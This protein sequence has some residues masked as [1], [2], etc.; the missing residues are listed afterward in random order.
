M[1]YTSIDIVNAKK[2]H[3]FIERNKSIVWSWLSTFYMYSPSKKDQAPF[4][5]L[6]EIH[7]SKNIRRNT[8]NFLITYRCLGHEEPKIS[9]ANTNLCRRYK[10]YIITLHLRWAADR[11]HL[12]EDLSL[13][14]LCSISQIRSFQLKCR[15]RR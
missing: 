8:Y 12:Q 3:S 6:G 5:Q 2:A 7:L 14:S 10:F 13:W 15:C 4:V 11:E 9:Y 1:T